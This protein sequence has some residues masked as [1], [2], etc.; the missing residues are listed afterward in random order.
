VTTYTHKD[1]NNLFLVKKYESELENDEDVEVVRNGDLIRLEHVTTRRNI[2]S[3]KEMAPISKKH[4]Q[5][6]GY[7]EV[8]KMVKKISNCVCV[9]CI[10]LSFYSAIWWFYIIILVSA[11][12]SLKIMAMLSV[13]CVQHSL[14][15]GHFSLVKSQSNNM[16]EL[17]DH[18]ISLLLVGTECCVLGTVS[19]SRMV[20]EMQMMCGRSWLLVVRKMTLWQQFLAS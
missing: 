11:L 6:T 2:H 13:N 20:L 7:G 8:G 4:Y 9:C 5:V 3:H 17:Y 14:L 12:G 15:V 1:D 16:F 18:G 10:I 19:H